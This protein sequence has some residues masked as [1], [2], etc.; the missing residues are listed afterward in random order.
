M[1]RTDCM[2]AG[3][4]FLFL[5]LLG[6]ESALVVAQRGLDSGLPL[7]CDASAAFEHEAATA[8]SRRC[9]MLIDRKSVV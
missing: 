8:A 4:A 1:T 7:R 3:S 5:G 9:D 6:G 2:A